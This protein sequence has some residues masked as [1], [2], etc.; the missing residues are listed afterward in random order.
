MCKSRDFRKDNLGKNENS[1]F[2][3]YIVMEIIKESSSRFFSY[4]DVVEIPSKW[5]SFLFVNFLPE[6]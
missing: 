3:C 5:E 4:E 2:P 6:S 1:C